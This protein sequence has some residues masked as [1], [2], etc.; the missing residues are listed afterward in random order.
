[1]IGLD[2]ISAVAITLAVVATIILST[3]STTTVVVFPI[4]IT[5]AALGLEW[6]WTHRLRKGEESELGAEVEKK[7]SGWQ[8]R[9]IGFYSAL[10][11]VVML[12]TGYFFDWFDVGA[13]VGMATTDA[14]AYSLSIA[15]AEEVFFRLLIT[16]L[17]LVSHLP[18][19]LSRFSFLDTPAFKLIVSGV[20]FGLVHTARY[21]ASFESMAYVIVG[22]CALSFVSYKC[23]SITPAIIAHA[24]NNFLAVGGFLQ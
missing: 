23:K 14:Y 3:F 22:G 9:N 7:I 16:D 5:V 24:A 15:V 13:I 17:L 10:A 8:L 1:M 18:A 2:K 4:T 12:G 6:V 21:G 11:L 20:F 19:S